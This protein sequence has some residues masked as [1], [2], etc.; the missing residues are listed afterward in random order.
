MVGM[1]KTDVAVRI[2]DAFVGEDAVGDHELAYVE[3]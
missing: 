1:A 3:V 2:D